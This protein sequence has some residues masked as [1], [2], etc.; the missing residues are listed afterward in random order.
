MLGRGAVSIHRRGHPEADG[1]D[2]PPGFPRL[3]EGRIQS[4]DDGSAPSLVRVIGLVE[5]D[6]FATQLDAAQISNGRREVRPS[7]VH[8]HDHARIRP[9]LEA[10]G[11]ASLDVLTCCPRIRQLTEEAQLHQLADGFDRR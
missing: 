5:F 11:R 8:A 1:Q 2:A 10:S 3:P 4:R 9:Q 6:D 7:G